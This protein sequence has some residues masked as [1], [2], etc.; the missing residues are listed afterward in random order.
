MRRFALFL[1]LCVLPLQFL[2]AA[3]VDARLHVETR[4]HHDDASYPNE[5]A[6]KPAPDSANA[7]ES[8]SRSHGD[9]GACHCFHSAA[10]LDTRDDF[11]RPKGAACIVPNGFD[12]H[13]RSASTAR[14]ERP[15]WSSLV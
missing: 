5:A 4:H 10:M 9:C 8:S 14:P 12:A 3:S 6:S 15:N 11:K 13:H 7:D 2:L 1:L